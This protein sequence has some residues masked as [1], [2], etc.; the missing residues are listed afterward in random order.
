MK[1]LSRLLVSA[2]LALVTS[3]AFTQPMPMP[4]SL[5]GGQN[6]TEILK[7][8]GLSDDQTK[9]VVDIMAKELVAV[10]PQRAQLKVLN[11]Q[12]E[13][14]MTA[15]NPDLK[16]VD[17]L[18]DKKTQLRGDIEKQFLAI[19]A[20]VHQIVGDQL[21]YQLRQHFLRS[22]RHME[23]FG[24]AWNYPQVVPGAKP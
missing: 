5:M 4:M 12:I 16:A 14:A 18:V 10:V 24:T 19:E 7:R 3:F 9:Q 20:Q 22:S 8:L 21:F 13:L 1:T 17:A 2:V 6:H 11:A 15:T 23:G